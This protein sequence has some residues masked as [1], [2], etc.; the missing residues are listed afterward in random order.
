MP[1]QILEKTFEDAI[2]DCLSNGSGYQVGDAANFSKELALDRTVLF[3]FVSTSQSQAWQKLSDIHG[4]SVEPKFL[5]RLYQE[6]EFR[7]MLDVLRHGIT[8]YGVRFKLAYFKPASNLNPETIARYDQNI[9]TVTRQVYY[10]T[11]N[12]NS[13]DLL[14]S[15]N[16]LPTATVELKNQFTGQDV[17]DAKAQYEQDRD[18]HEL[19]FQ[20]KRRAFVHFTVDAD[21]AWM[22]TRI[23]GS[24][25]RFLPFNQGYQKGAGNPPNPQGHR[26]Y[27]L[28]ETIWAKDSWL[29]IIDRFLHLEQ[30]TIKLNG[31]SAKKESLIF[32]RYHQ[33]DVVRK[34][35]A[36][37]KANGAGHNYLIQH[38]AG[39]GKSNSIA[40]LTYQLANLYN[41]KDT[42]VFD[43]VIVITD[44]K[45]LDRQ[46]Q[47]TIYQFDHVAGVVQKIDRNAEQLAKALTSGTNIIIT[48]LQKFPFVLDKIGKLPQRNYAL[49]VDEAHSSQGGE[50]TK[51]MKEAL[52]VTDLSRA[53]NSDRDEADDEDKI[54][55]SVQRHAQTRGKQ[56]NLSF[57]A[58]TA[59]PK[60]KTLEVFGQLNKEGKPA[61]FDLYS[62]RQAI[63]EGFIMDVLKNYTTYKTYF[64]LT[65]AIEDDPQ[66]HKK[67]AS[68]A[69]ARFLSLHPHNLAQKTE[70]IVEHFRQCVMHRIGGKAKA[71]LVTASRPH[72]VR[73]KE[74]FDKY[75]AKKGYTD[76]R[77]LVA[78]TSFTDRET[79]IAYS[80]SDMNGFGEKELPEKF[81]TREY[82]LLIVADKYQTGFDQPLLHTMYVDKKLSGVR[83]VQTLSRLNR[84]CPGKEETFVLDFANEEQEIIDAFQPYYERTVLESTTDPNRLYDLKNQLDSFQIIWQSEIDAFAKVFFKPTERITRRDHARLNALIDPACDRF[85]GLEEDPQDEFKN[86]I[87]T[88]IRL[89]A[90]LAQIMPFTDVALEKFYAFARLLQTKLPKRL[91]SEVFKLT[92]EVGLEYYRLQKIR[93]GQIILEKDANSLLYPSLDAGIPKEKEMQAKLSEIVEILNKRFK[94]DFADADKLFF[95]QIEE[96][97][98]NNASLSQQAKSNSIQNFKYGFDDVFLNTL[99]ERMEDNQDIFTKIIDNSEF[100]DAVKAWML[101][102]VYD[103]LNE[104]E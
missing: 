101:Q 1:S 85:K 86:A 13:I 37:A 79:G 52:T 11:Q 39:S 35:T 95:S 91:Q 57:F 84:I 59:T 64:R 60:P 102:K 9:L 28:W 88:F 48:T 27:Y 87:A 100:G 65:K 42:R 58:F 23:E 18:N 62:M 68:R 25:T 3:Q 32:P 47:D 2:V 22:T 94:T 96:E 82:Q 38:S 10:S 103:R 20:F 67:K 72:V 89:Y 77:A 61:P 12:Q 81:E 78:F 24:K 26:T 30:D 6:L 40:W 44:R 45:I 46:L 54:R 14:L 31:K 70:I 36:H 98:V 7:G 41:E 8:D 83:A 56:T 97:L 63:E 16:G 99:I 80:E 90:F 17:E 93:E 21:E 76:I 104:T 75:I 33:L 4:S 71:M 69:I 43:S 15:V 74:E 73:Y 53:E 55:E 34:L 49:I 51:Q 5:Q 66:I 19:L 92:D 50:T 29:D